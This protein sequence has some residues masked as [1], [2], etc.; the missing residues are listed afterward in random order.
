MQRRYAVWRPVESLL[1]SI[2]IYCAELDIYTITLC[3]ACRKC[4]QWPPL[5]QE[6]TFPFE[7]EDGPSQTCRNTSNLRWSWTNKTNRR[8]IQITSYGVPPIHLPPAQLQVAH[9]HNV[10]VVILLYH[11]FHHV[12][13]ELRMTV[14]STQLQVPPPRDV[15]WTQDDIFS[16]GNIIRGS[17]IDSTHWYGS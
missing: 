2:E 13:V 16:L 14:K 11:T 8:R 5:L 15:M 7:A 17:M 10:D 6:N 3:N 12:A 4:P 1:R 9:I